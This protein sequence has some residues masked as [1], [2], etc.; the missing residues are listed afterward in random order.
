MTDATCQDD[1]NCRQIPAQS[2]TAE[3]LLRSFGRAAFW[4]PQFANPTKS[5]RKVLATKTFR[6]NPSFPAGLGQPSR[7]CGLL[8]I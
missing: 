4:L 5:Q 2:F 8:W 6:A 7:F 3:K 1:F